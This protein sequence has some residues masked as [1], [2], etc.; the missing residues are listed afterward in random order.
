[1]SVIVVSDDKTLG[2]DEVGELICAEAGCTIT[3]PHENTYACVIGDDTEITSNTAGV[4]TVDAEANV[5]LLGAGSTTVTK[6]K[7]LRAIYLGSNKF[8]LR[9]S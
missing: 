5:T 8:L 2:Q 7:A 1:M 9:S 6:G 3:L 4:V